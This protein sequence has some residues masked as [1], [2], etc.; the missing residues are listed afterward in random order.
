MTTN[1]P[2]WSGTLPDPAQPDGSTCWTAPTADRTPDVDG[3]S[4]WAE[5][6]GPGGAPPVV[7]DG[8]HTR[9][10]WLTC[11]RGKG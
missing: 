5:P 9:P 2:G 1:A 11:G 10:G 8:P 7:A 4:P 6:D 3:L